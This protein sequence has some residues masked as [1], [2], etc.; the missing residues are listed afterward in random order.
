MSPAPTA[1]PTFD[2]VVAAPRFSEINAC[3]YFPPDVSARLLGDPWEVHHQWSTLTQMTWTLDGPTPYGWAACENYPGGWVYATRRPMSR[4]EEIA[5]IRS[6]FGDDGF[7]ATTIQG[8]TILIR[9]CAV[10]PRLCK[11][12]MAI[13]VY[14]H[15]VIITFPKRESH[16]TLRA[17][18]DA[19]IESTQGPG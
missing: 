15:F 4:S 7:S 16:A 14:P 3:E 2:A 19:V 13:S 1:T 9:G 8:K 11:P 5:V 18:A 6:A 10:K 12:A 17:A